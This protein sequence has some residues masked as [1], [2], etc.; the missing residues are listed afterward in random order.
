MCFESD[1]KRETE[2]SP[3]RSAADPRRKIVLLAVLLGAAVIVG[4]VVRTRLGVEWN[5]DLIRGVVGHFG[6]WAPVAFMGIVAGRMFLFLPAALVLTVAGALFGTLQ[7]TVYGAIGLTLSAVMAFGLV[8]AVGHEALRARMPARFQPLLELGRSRSGTALL[9][10]LSGYP[11]G[12]SVWAQAGAAVS[13][14]ALV[15]FALAVSFGSAVRAGTYSIFGNALMEGH[16]VWI[17][18][19]LLGAAF[20]LPLLHPRARALVREMMR[21]AESTPGRVAAPQ[22]GGPSSA[23]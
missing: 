15:P 1:A 4:H 17:G 19:A 12:P 20:T 11:I 14:M 22:P 3:H 13:G 23:A 5:A 16:G 21:P 9:T 2:P 8:R 10:V 7:G 6:L 18:A